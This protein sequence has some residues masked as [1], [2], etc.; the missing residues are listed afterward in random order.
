VWTALARI[1]TS[2]VGIVNDVPYLQGPP[3][4]AP[5]R[6]EALALGQ[7]WN[8]NYPTHLTHGPSS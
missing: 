4:D 8:A 7:I 1:S 6:Q 2:A 3:A 5:Q